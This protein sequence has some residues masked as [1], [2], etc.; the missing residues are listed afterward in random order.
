M[1]L[2]REP[3][4]PTPPPLIIRENPP[5]APRVALQP[6]IIEKII[7]PPTPPPRQVILERYPAPDKPRDIIYEVIINLK[8][9][10]INSRFISV[11]LE[12]VAI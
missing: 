7:P 11:L 5:M 9:K 6:T 8:C 3:S 10:F 2:K 4:P 12:M 1:F